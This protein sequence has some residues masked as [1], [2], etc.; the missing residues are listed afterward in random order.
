MRRGE[1]RKLVYPRIYGPN[2]TLT[3]RFAGTRWE[4]LWIVAPSF[5]STDAGPALTANIR[6]TIARPA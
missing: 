3:Q 1:A 6:N 5:N 4:N 2:W